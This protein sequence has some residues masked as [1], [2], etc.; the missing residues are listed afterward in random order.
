M[1]VAFS[2]AFLSELGKILFLCSRAFLNPEH[3]GDNLATI[4]IGCIAN[5]I[6]RG[7]IGVNLKIFVSFV[8]NVRYIL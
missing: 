7:K 1:T 4:E 3:F 6:C 5:Y 8:Y 2:G